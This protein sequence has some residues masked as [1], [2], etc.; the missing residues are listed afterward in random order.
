MEPPEHNLPKGVDGYL[1]ALRWGIL[2]AIGIIYG[3][4]GPSVT[5]A[6]HPAPLLDPKL[7]LVL[8]V[9]YN[10]PLTFY[11]LR[12]HPI[13]AEKPLALLL[14][15][16]L[17]ALA[18]VRFTGGYLSA[19]FL[20][21]LIVLI[22]AAL[23]Y[24]WRTALPLLILLDAL[25]LLATAPTGIEVAPILVV[26]RFV[27][28]LLFGQYLR[29]EEA[30]RR[31]IALHATQERL[32][33]EF[34]FQLGASHMDLERVLQVI[35]DNACDLFGAFCAL[36]LL[37]EGDKLHLAA[38]TISLELDAGELTFLPPRSATPPQ[39]LEVQ[40]GA[41]N[42]PT[43]ASACAIRRLVGVPL[44]SP[45]QEAAGWLLLGYDKATSPT[46]EEHQLLTTLGMEA[47]LA[48]RNAQL[49]AREQEHIRALEQFNEARANFFSA[50]GHELKT[51]LTVLKTL[52]PALNR[53][54]ELPPETR[55]EIVQSI[56][57]NLERLEGL[58]DH[59]FESARLE[60]G[61]V[62]LHPH[63][64]DLHSRVERNLSAIQPLADQ[65][66]LEVNATFPPHLPRV[67]ADPQ[68]FDQILGN[69]LHNAVKFSPPGGKVA[70]TVTAS[71]HEATVC[72]D[73]TGPGIPP[74]LRERIFDKFVTAS[75]G[76][77]S[78]GIGLGLYIA[79]ELV[80][81]HGGRIWATD[82]PLG[83]SRFCFTLPVDKETEEE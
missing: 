40:R 59:L 77:A 54:T 67:Q 15:D 14:G 81:L 80:R 71:D 43:F 10:L 18:L 32:L 61:A 78:V 3:L 41:A 46:T 63:P 21:F 39:I 56:Q 22:E 44:R 74:E 28:A 82:S 35:L 48:L 62:A 79:R 17:F 64:L 53:L 42:W 8:L 9:V 72:V 65:K 7:A 29:Q 24:R 37:Y 11:I 36:I 12:E 60:S 33:N 34:F 69:L 70:V 58:I 27:A 47:G 20:I 5:P 23:A 1:L 19:F 30:E 13:A 38:A 51:P 45:G 75:P 26:N 68:R 66:G 25:Q 50:L 73:D 31:S 55:A 83:G 57:L 2:A 52:G 16:T 49:Y 76:R 4:T 6:L